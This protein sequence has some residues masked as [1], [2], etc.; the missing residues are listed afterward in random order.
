MKQTGLPKLGWQILR[1]LMVK[2]TKLKF[3]VINKKCQNTEILPL[4][5]KF[6]SAEKINKTK[7]NL[8]LTY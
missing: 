3:F 6:N 7:F 5:T 8:I 2:P 1:G 4:K